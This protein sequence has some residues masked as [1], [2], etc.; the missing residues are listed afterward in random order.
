M[1]NGASRNKVLKEAKKLRSILGMDRVYIKPD[2]TEA[3]R[4]LER[5]LRL[6][7]D[8]LNE[9]EI[10][11]G[12][13]FRWSIFRGEIRKYRT[14]VP[15]EANGNEV[16]VGESTTASV[17]NVGRMRSTA[18]VPNAGSVRLSNT[19]SNSQHVERASKC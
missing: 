19:V 2:Q 4:V 17:P 1:N 12:S 8:E 7:R 6:R 18:S 3:E 15:R 10:E 11:Q 14:E 13:L 16:F 9:E 5:Q